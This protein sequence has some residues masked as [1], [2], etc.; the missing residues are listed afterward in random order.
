[1]SDR[2]THS[3]SPPKTVPENVSKERRPTQSTSQEGSDAINGIN[4]HNDATLMQ[5]AGQET[6]PQE[7]GVADFEEV[8][9]GVIN[10]AEISEIQYLSGDKNMQTEIVG[11]EPNISDV[12]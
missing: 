8:T 4:Y 9:D 2:A 11:L 1:M 5:T 6:N 3:P 12:T 7:T 10:G